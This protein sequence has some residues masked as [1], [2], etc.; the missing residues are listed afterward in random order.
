MALRRTEVRG[1]E[2]LDH[3]EFSCLAVE[4][5]GKAQQQL[6][7]VVLVVFVVALAIGLDVDELA[8]EPRHTEERR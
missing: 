7:K 2:V 4:L 5:D 3:A 6:A 8:A 1:V